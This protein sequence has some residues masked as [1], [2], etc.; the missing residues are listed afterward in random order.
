MVLLWGLMRTFMRMENALDLPTLASYMDHTL[1]APTAREDDIRLLCDEAVKYGFKAVCVNG[2]YLGVA[3]QQLG[4]APVGLAAVV[5]FPLGA[6]GTLAKCLEAKTYLE[7][8]VG[9]LD[10]V[11]PVGWVKSGMWNQVLTELHRLRETAPHACL[12]LI[13]ET[14]YLNSSQKTKLCELAREAKWDYVKTSTG[15]GTGGATLEDIALMK[16]AMNGQLRIKAS[17]GIRDLDTALSYIR[18]GVSRIGTSSAV[19]ILQEARRRAE[20]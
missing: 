11:A 14:C 2:C 12:K 4:N 18:A 16:R 1:L 7:E 6:T 3:R 17:G 5:G 20:A 8:G 13:L 9:E 15:F 19:H 10:V